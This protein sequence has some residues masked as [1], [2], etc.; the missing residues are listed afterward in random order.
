MIPRNYSAIAFKIY[1]IV[2]SLPVAIGVVPMPGTLATESPWYGFVTLWSVVLGCAVSLT[3]IFMMDHLDGSVVEQVG[4]TFV[5]LWLVGYG[6]ALTKAL[7]AGWWP[8]TLC[9]GISFFFGLQWR[10]IWRWRRP[11]KQKIK[12]HGT[13]AH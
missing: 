5:I 2:V 7:P 12:E 3:G 13:R 9:F 11:L 1:L 10:E 4:L 8:M 6:L